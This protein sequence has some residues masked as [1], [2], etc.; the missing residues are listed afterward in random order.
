MLSGH[1][2]K[3]V[4][5]FVPLICLS[6]AGYFGYHAVKSMHKLALLESDV[7]KTKAKLV[8]VKAR[9][10]A[11]ERRVSLLRP[12]SLDPDMLDERARA[13]VNAARAEDIVIFRSKRK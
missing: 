3:A 1:K 2:F 12:G 13:A 7:A 4:F 5:L 8:T 11:L 6:I 9:R 10:Q